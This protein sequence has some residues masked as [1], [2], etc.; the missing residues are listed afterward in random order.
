MN[1]NDFEILNNFLNQKIITLKDYTV[2]ELELIKTNN[3]NNSLYKFNDDITLDIK[4]LSYNDYYVKK[5]Y[6][7]YPLILILLDNPLYILMYTNSYFNFTKQLNEIFDLMDMYQE[8]IKNLLLNN[9]IM[10]LQTKAIFELSTQDKNYICQSLNSSY[11]NIINN[12]FIENIFTYNIVCSFFGIKINYW[13]NEGIQN[14][15]VNKKL[16]VL[17]FL[18][19]KMGINNPSIFNILDIN[20]IKNE[21]KSFYSYYITFNIPDDV[22]KYYIGCN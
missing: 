22:R 19:K 16:E 7:G 17:D 5:N 10:N 21:K 11:E 15:I 4:L 18:L 1:I 20:F 8:N 9:Q 3:T 12:L 13:H 6:E 2:N 14:N